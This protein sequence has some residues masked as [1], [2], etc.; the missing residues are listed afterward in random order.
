MVCS[1][2]NAL[3]VGALVVAL[4]KRLPEIDLDGLYDNK[5]TLDVQQGKAAYPAAHHG[6]IH[7][8]QGKVGFIGVG[9]MGH[10]MAKNIV[11]KGFD[12]VVLRHRKAEAV[13]DL[14]TRGATE[15]TSLRDMAEQCDRIVLC[16]TGTPQVEALVLGADGLA[17][18]NRPLLLIDCSTSEPESTRQLAAK[19]APQNIRIVD[20]P[21]S[22]S[23][24]EAWEGTLD[25][26]A[27]GAAADL[28]E[29]LPL[30]NCFARRVVETGEVGTGH[31]LKLLNNSVSLG[32][33][34]I[35]AEALMLGAK[36]G[37]TPEIIHKVLAGGRMDCP[38]FQTLLRLR[39]GRQS[40]GAPLHH[41]QCA[42]GHDLHVQ[43]GRCACRRQ[44]GR[45][46][47]SQL[48]GARGRS[49]RRRALP[50][51]S[52]GVDSRGEWRGAAGRLIGIV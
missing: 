19:L 39:G 20:A 12:L 34:A 21:L 48:A 35:Y 28:A 17:S 1:M 8:V 24:K 4:M 27:G 26:M 6:T 22:R 51:A 37:I 42:E 10:G 11:E 14:K 50:A 36:S 16:V 38:F 7:M 3:P 32:Y 40:R 52:R 13:E 44:P 41:A 29:A 46:R 43:R 33:A 2:R 49:R 47:G 25:V 23:P 15:A 18:A 9:L 45:Q 30:L 31:T 5:T